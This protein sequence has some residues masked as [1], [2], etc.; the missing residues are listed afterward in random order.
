MIV[1][2]STGAEP[3]TGY[4]AEITRMDVQN[5]VL[6]VHWRVIAPGAGA[7]VTQVTTNNAQAVLTDRFDGKV[8]FDLPP[9][10]APAPAPG[11]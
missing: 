10:K 1:I 7:A 3:T 2:V 8:V 6:T 4:N 5:D 11:R 9:A